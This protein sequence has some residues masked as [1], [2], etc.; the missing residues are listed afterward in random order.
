MPGLQRPRR[1][2]RAGGPASEGR[3][4]MGAPIRNPITRQPW[5]PKT[6]CRPPCRLSGAPRS[7]CVFWVPSATGPVRPRPRLPP[8]RRAASQSPVPSPPLQLKRKKRRAPVLTPTTFASRLP[9]PARRFRVTML[10]RGAQVAA[11]PPAPPPPPAGVTDELPH[12]PPTRIEQTRITLRARTNGA[13]HR[14]ETTT[15]ACCQC[16]SEVPRYGGI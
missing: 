1:R 5:C 12:A 14:R 3:L 4:T 10:A 8:S 7:P 16:G 2:Q 13:L 6:H 11:S 15:A 9:D